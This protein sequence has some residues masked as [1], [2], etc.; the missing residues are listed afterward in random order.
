MVDSILIKWPTYADDNFSRYLFSS[1]YS[2]R[3]KK[4]SKVNH[5]TGFDRGFEAEKILGATDTAA[6]GELHFLISW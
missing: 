3:K 6:G 1:S 5:V 2:S 4:K